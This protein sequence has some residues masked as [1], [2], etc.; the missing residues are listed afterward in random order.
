MRPSDLAAVCRRH[1]G[2]SSWS[3]TPTRVVV[4]SRHPMRLAL[5]VPCGLFCPT[6]FLIFPPNRLYSSIRARLAFDLRF[7]TANLENI[8]AKF[9][10]GVHDAGTHCKKWVLAE[11]GQHDSDVRVVLATSAL[12]FG[13]NLRGF[14]M[15][16]VLETP[17]GSFSSVWR[18]GTG[19]L[20]PLHSARGLSFCSSSGV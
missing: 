17:V 5:S 12:S 7:D 13:V 14:N 3:M 6:L 4:F 9:N 16:I 2:P 10:A 11:L 18:Y 1:P 8:V 15:A 20:T 19:T